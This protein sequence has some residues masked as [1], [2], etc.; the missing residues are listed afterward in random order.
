MVQIDATADCIYVSSSR[1][2]LETSQHLLLSSTAT[3]MK[4]TGCECTRSERQPG[5]ILFKAE[6]ANYET[7]LLSRK[8]CCLSFY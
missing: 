4:T 2:L 6:V 7:Y 8:V 3:G 5:R 1:Q